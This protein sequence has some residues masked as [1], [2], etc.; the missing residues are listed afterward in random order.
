MRSKSRDPQAEAAAA[1]MAHA[2]PAE[3]HAIA[4]IATR[5][6]RL[7]GRLEK[8][9]FPLVA[10]PLAGLLTRSEN[11]TAT[12]RIEALIHLAAVACQG[13]R[14]PGLRQLD[15]WLNVEFYDDPITE[16]EGSCRGSVRLG[17]STRG[18]ATRASS[19]ALAEQRRACSRCVETLL[20]IQDRPWT[21][22]TLGHVVALLRVPG[23]DETLPPSQG[24]RPAAAQ[25]V[26]GGRGPAC[27]GGG[28]RRAGA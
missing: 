11:H 20:R 3:L 14:T 5:L 13:D 27:A 15:E 21:E 12:A 25:H 16:H 1:L 19:A 23:P 22:Q 28:G 18:S 9:S 10:A 26:P 6:A 4:S 2:A 7:V 17:M 8:F 24:P